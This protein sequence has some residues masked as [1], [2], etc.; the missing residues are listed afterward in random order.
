MRNL[1]IGFFAA[2]FSVSSFAGSLTVTNTFTADTTARASEVNQ[3]F[4]DVKTAVDDNDGRIKTNALDISTNAGNISDNASNITAN[5]NA[6][7]AI[8]S[9]LSVLANGTPVGIFIGFDH[10][11][12]GVNLINSKGYLFRIRTRY[13]GSRPEGA[14]SNRYD[15]FYQSADCTGP[16]YIQKALLVNSPPAGM[17]AANH[18]VVFD[19]NG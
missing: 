14:I 11:Y 16:E 10:T 13:D 18:G 2:M 7:A 1:I 3:N 19:V 6:L 4:T 9:P 12:R 5:T 8:V 15:V 17:I